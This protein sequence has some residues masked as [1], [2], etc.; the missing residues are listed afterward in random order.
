MYNNNYSHE[1]SCLG[2]DWT[3][4][5]YRKHYSSKILQNL[6]Y[7]SN[8]SKIDKQILYIF[9]Q[10]TIAKAFTLELTERTLTISWSLLMKALFFKNLP[11]PNHYLYTLHCKYF[12]K[13]TNAISYKRRLYIP[14]NEKKNCVNVSKITNHNLLRWKLSG[15]L[16]A[17]IIV[18]ATIR[19]LNYDQ[20][21]TPLPW[22]MCN[23][24]IVSKIICLCFNLSCFFMSLS[25][26][27]KI[28]KFGLVW[29]S[30]LCY[31]YYINFAHDFLGI[32]N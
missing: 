28:R 18:C 25:V 3:N 16:F 17:I 6:R 7:I 15:V 12:Q 27:V 9:L 29:W 1:N 5:H 19:I 26:Q 4:F 22:K 20:Y 32:M 14:S 11:N 10:I 30:L 23:T 2:I 13:Q 8:I 31:N 24:R 21:Q